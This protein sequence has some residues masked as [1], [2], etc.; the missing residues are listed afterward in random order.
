VPAVPLGSRDLPTPAIEIGESNLSA[1][2]SESHLTPAPAAP[3]AVARLVSLDQFR[4]YTVAGMLF[5]NFL[6]GFAVIPAVLK[7]HHTYCSYADTIMPQFL[8]A[9]G[10]AFRLT[11]GRRVQTQ[12]LAA[13][14]RRAIRRFFGLA[15]VAIVFYSYEDGGD[16]WEHL[17]TAE[18]W[19]TLYGSAKRT[20]FQTLMHIAV[21][22]LWILPVI[23][24]SA[25]VRISYMIVSCCAHVYLS[26]VFN[27]AWVNTGPVGIDG[28]PLGFLTWCIPML[29]GSV[30][31]D[32]VMGSALRPNI[33]KMLA[34]STALMVFAYIISCGTRLY[35]LQPGEENLPELSTTP[36]VPPSA[37]LQGRDFA[38]LLAEPPFVQPPSFK[39]RQ[40]NYW[41]MSQRSG[42]ASYLIFSAGFSLAVFVLFHLACDRLGWQIGVL[43]TLGTNALLA[44]ILGSVIGA[45]I[46]RL[47]KEDALLLQALAAFGC[48]LLSVYLVLRILEW[49]KI[50]IRV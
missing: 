36:V 21:T 12:G 41:M 15:L 32:A 49:R 26:H 24:A 9:V 40:G 7:H 31:C 35:D 45:P 6:G 18:L 13:A 23:R 27:F 46:Q 1:G 3:A 17:G 11:F 30:A 19:N 5:V 28:G 33:G 4:G 42:T 14:Y 44:Y 47:V 10:F 34:W 25:A 16:M 43:R 50:Y 8:F 37:H 39:L 29:V 48:S 22:S 2:V 38:S 20:W